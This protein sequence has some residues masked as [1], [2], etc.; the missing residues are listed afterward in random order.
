VA[1]FPLEVLDDAVHRRR[2]AAAV[3]AAHQHLGPRVV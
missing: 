1:V 3:G 2:L